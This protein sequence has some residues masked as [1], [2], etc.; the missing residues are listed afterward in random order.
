MREKRQRDWIES[1]YTLL[2]LLFAFLF[3]NLLLVLCLL[4]FVLSWTLASQDEKKSEWEKKRLCLE[5]SNGNPL[6][7]Q[8]VKQARKTLERMQL[9]LL[10]SFFLFHF[11]AFNGEQKAVDWKC[12]VL[13]SYLVESTDVQLSTRHNGTTWPSCFVFLLRGSEEKHTRK[14]SKQRHFFEFTQKTLC[15]LWETSHH[16]FVVNDYWLFWKRCMVVE[17]NARKLGLDI[18]TDML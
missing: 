1:Q 5:N 16:S 17:K 18:S 8:R 3:F 6:H 12:L 7:L 11:V 14:R 4:S 13:P 9:T 10:V 2:V 15:L